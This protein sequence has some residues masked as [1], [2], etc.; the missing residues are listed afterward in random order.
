RPFACSCDSTWPAD[1]PEY[2]CPLREARADQGFAPGQDAGNGP[3]TAPTT[4][5]HGFLPC[6][7]R[8]RGRGDHRCATAPPIAVDGNSICQCKAEPSCRGTVA[9]SASRAFETNPGK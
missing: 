9:P 4:Q 1:L 8:E 2:S 5:V 7:W 6:C 3:S